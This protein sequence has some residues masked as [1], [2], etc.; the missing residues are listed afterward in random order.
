[1]WGIGRGVLGYE[2]CMGFWCSCPFILNQIVVEISS[3]SWYVD[4]SLHINQKDNQTKHEATVV[5]NE[6][7][8]KICIVLTFLPS[9][10][11]RGG[12]KLLNDSMYTLTNW[13]MNNDL[14]VAHPRSG[15]S[16]TWF[17]VELEF[18][19]VGFWWE[20]KTGVPG[21]KPLAARGR[22]NNKLGEWGTD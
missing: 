21:E 22:T 11:I 8:L 14:E 1:M 20:G 15:S 19:N 7:N 6:C 4:Y 17:L 10:F 3:D 9:V 16:S 2:K 13:I 5:K 12:Q 18:G